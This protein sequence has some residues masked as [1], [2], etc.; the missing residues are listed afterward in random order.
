[1]DKE[2][3]EFALLQN[4]KRD[5]TLDSLGL[6]SRDEIVEKFVYEELEKNAKDFC[7]LFAMGLKCHEVGYLNCYF[8]ACPHYSINDSSSA[9]AINSRFA[10]FVGAVLDCSKCKVPHTKGFVKARLKKRF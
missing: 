7:P 2:I 6:G 4:K 9:C 1:M 10:T 5:A 3:V 8:C